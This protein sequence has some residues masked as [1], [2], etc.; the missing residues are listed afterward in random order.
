MTTTFPR[1]TQRTI[2][3]TIFIMGIAM[4]AFGT[5][6][7]AYS[8]TSAPSTSITASPDASTNTSYT[9]M[10]GDEIDISVL[11]HDDL[12]TDAT[13][14]PDGTITLPIAGV[15][16]AS[17]L[18][19]GQL[20]DAIAHGM[21]TQLNQPEVSVMVKQRNSSSVS[22]LGAVKEPG[23]HTLR[24]GWRVLDL[25][26]D[27]GGLSDN[28][29]Q[30]VSCT[31]V[32]GSQVTQVDVAALM[33]DPT[34][35]RN[36]VLRPNDMVLIQERDPRYVAVEV[37]GEVAHPG[38]TAVPADGS[39]A[40]VLASVGGTNPNAEL[41]SATINRQGTIL[42]VDLR[43]LSQA[44]TIA[45]FPTLQAGDILSVPK[46]RNLYG[47]FGEVRA[48][49]YRVYPDD[50]SLTVLMA[51]SEAG[52]QS[53][54][55]DMKKVSVLHPTP[56]QAGK[57][58]VQTADLDDGLKQGDLTHDVPIQPG[59]LIYVPGH[60]HSGTNMLQYLSPLAAVVSLGAHL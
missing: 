54:D 40:T 21:S 41:S 14:L 8:I 4:I 45:D 43:E 22:I 60:H 20:G 31:V 24:D 10:P 23:S 48:P 19:P 30:A 52:A 33:K 17:G 29:P 15:V 27:A 1:N 53:D 28:N 57:Y 2:I 47:V 6:R 37:L 38:F 26:G 18:T 16:H 56:G 39:I 58:T 11:G 7:P 5:S 50:R 3:S 12:R 55:A 9:L 49:G 35:D 51:I 42:P 34:P 36:I 32:R 13:I 44:S 25:I 59:D 46:N